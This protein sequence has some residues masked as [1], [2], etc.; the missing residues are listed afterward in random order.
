M[1]DQPIESR[2]HYVFRMSASVLA[3]DVVISL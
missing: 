3:L 1:D 2:M